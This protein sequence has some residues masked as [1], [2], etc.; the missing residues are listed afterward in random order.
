MEHIA[1]ADATGPDR[2]T[3]VDGSGAWFSAAAEARNCTRVLG[4]RRHGLD[5]LLT[6]ARAAATPS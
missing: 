5:S 6:E 4:Q 3:A 1:D 2:M